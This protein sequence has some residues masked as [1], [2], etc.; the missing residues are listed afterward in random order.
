LTTVAA[1]TKGK[2]LPGTAI[3]G[4]NVFTATDTITLTCSSTTVFSE[5]TGEIQLEAVNDD[6]RRGVGAGNMGLAYA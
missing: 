1:N 2:V 4:N 5:G 6:T 3:T